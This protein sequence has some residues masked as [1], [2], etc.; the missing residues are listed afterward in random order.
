[1]DASLLLRS[2]S[3]LERTA[4]I[5]TVLAREGHTLLG[6]RVGMLPALTGTLQP[7]VE[8]WEAP[9][10]DRVSRYCFSGAMGFSHSTVS[11]KVL[12][13]NT[14]P[15]LPTDT[16]TQHP[17]THSAHYAQHTCAPQHRLPSS[18]S[19]RGIRDVFKLKHLG[20]TSLPFRSLVLG[21]TPR[22]LK[23]CISSTFSRDAFTAGPGPRLR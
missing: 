9:A 18:N 6:T 19:Q 20:P 21:L 5:H 12:V 10:R 7:P 22:I 8:N 23:F 2:R 1:M 3:Q 15:H 17:H 13:S 11:A 14:P 4:Q 16:H